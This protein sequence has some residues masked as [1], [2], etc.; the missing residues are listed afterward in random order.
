MVKRKIKMKPTEWSTLQVD[1][2][3]G[4][5]AGMG[6]VFEIMPPEYVE[7]LVAE[8]DIVPALR[9]HETALRQFRK[10]VEALQNGEPGTECERCGKR[11]HARRGARFCSTA[12]RVA[13]H[14]G[15]T[16]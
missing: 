1:G 3:L 12:C 5:A 6:D 7:A 15:S 4:Q 14:R 8:P 2:H 9:A 11:F 13:A 10:R 16:T